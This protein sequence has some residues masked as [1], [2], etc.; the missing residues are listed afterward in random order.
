MLFDS[1]LAVSLSL[2]VLVLAS[3]SAVALPWSERALRESAESWRWLG[4]WLVARASVSDPFRP[5]LRYS[6]PE[7]L[8]PPPLPWRVNRPQRS[9]IR[10][11]VATGGAAPTFDLSSGG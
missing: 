5:Q 9:A 10:G 7:M 1:I 2:L 8:L 4:A 3:L 6:S 11:H